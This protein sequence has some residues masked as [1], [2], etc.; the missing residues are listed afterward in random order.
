MAA[1]LLEQCLARPLPAPWGVLQ[2]DGSASQQGGCLAGEGEGQARHR[3]HLRELALVDTR[4][5]AL[6]PLML[7]STLLPQNITSESLGSKAYSSKTMYLVQNLI[8]PK[9]KL[10]A[11]R[12]DVMCLRSHSKLA[13]SLELGPCLLGLVTTPELHDTPLPGFEKIG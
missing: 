5:G 4:E 8:F 2:P 1:P 9:R 11:Q 10:K 7:S 6:G 3:V 12:G 13:T